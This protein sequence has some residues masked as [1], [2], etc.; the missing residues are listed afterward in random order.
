MT[1][2]MN[3]LVGVNMKPHQGVLNHIP[4]GRRLA[5]YEALKNNR[6]AKGCDYLCSI[7]DG[8]HRFTALGIYMHYVEEIPFL[9]LL[10]KKHPVD[11][12]P[13]SDLVMWDR[14]ISGTTSPTGNI[15]VIQTDKRIIRAR[16]LNDK[17]THNF[18][19]FGMMIFPESARL[20]NIV[21]TVNVL[22]IAELNNTTILVGEQSYA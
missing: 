11:A 15:P 4:Y 7:E 16:E 2:K 22:Q 1:T 14:M 19:V 13:E 18:D 20:Y 17:L 3:M 9:S 5:W 12:C 21:N 10:K 6:Y 8:L